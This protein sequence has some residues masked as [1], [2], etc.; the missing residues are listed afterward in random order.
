MITE[1]RTRSLYLV[2]Q[3]NQSLHCEAK[4]WVDESV[5][6]GRRGSSESVSWWVVRCAKEILVSVIYLIYYF[7]PLFLLFLL[8]NN[9][10]EEGG[11][12]R[13]NREKGMSEGRERGDRW[14]FLLGVLV[15]STLYYHITPDCLNGEIITYGNAILGK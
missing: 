7:F 1:C 4:C 9:E 5:L 10:E 14:N 15:F 13:R 6:I 3:W 12:W 11:G 2:H 8:L